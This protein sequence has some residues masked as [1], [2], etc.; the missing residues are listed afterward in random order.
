[1]FDTGSGGTAYRYR[2]VRVTLLDPVRHAH[3]TRC[4][5]LPQGL[6]KP[7]HHPVD[8]PQAELLG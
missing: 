6:E 5:G 8:Q 7:R 3:M 1:M 2:G 4:G